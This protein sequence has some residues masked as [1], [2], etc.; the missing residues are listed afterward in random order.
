[1]SLQLSAVF[2]CQ[3][4]LDY[5]RVSHG[6]PWNIRIGWF[7]PMCPHGCYPD[8]KASIIGTQGC[9][10][11]AGLILILAAGVRLSVLVAPIWAVFLAVKKWV[12]MIPGAPQFLVIWVRQCWNDAL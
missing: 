4:M 3:V 10:S 2:R 5:H 11:G 1:M 6:I 7:N 12:W 8:C 9:I